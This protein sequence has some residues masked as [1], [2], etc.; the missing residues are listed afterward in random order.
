MQDKQIKKVEME[1]KIEKLKNNRMSMAETHQIAIENKKRIIQ[2]D[3]I[4]RADLYK[5]QWVEFDDKMKVKKDSQKTEKERLA[6]EVR[7]TTRKNEI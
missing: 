2:E 7:E 1:H 5:K 4:K 3:E 6:K